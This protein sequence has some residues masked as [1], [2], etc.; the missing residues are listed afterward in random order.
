[1]SLANLTDREN[2]LL[3]LLSYQDIP[4]DQFVPG[5]SMSDVLGSTN[6]SDGLKQEILRSDNLSSLKIIDYAN[7]N[8]NSGKTSQGG[9]TYDS[10]FVGYCF[11]DSSGAH[12]FLF[13]GTEDMG[14][15]L[16]SVD[17]V[18]D[19]QSS[20]TSDSPQ[21]RDAREFF[22]KN[23]VDGGNNYLSGHS[24]GV[25][26][27]TEVYVDNPDDVA[28]VYGLNGQPICLAGLTAA[29]IVALKDPKYRFIVLPLDPVHHIK[30]GNPPYDTQYAMVDL[31]YVYKHGPLSIHDVGA[32]AY[33]EYGNHLK[34]P[35]SG[36]PVV[37]D[38]VLDVYRL[39]VAGTITVATARIF[40]DMAWA[41][42]VT[43]MQKG[44][45]EAKKLAENFV[46]FLKS[47]LVGATTFIATVEGFFSNLGDA[48][49]RGINSLFEG[50]G[51]GWGSGP[52]D[53][54]TDRLRSAAS[55]L[56]AAQNRMAS[57][58]HRLARLT[59]LIEPEKRWAVAAIDWSLCFDGRLGR[60]VSYLNWTAERLE[61]CERSIV[62]R[63]Y[64][65]RT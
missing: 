42:A 59:L 47:A 58:D 57:L 19:I 61:G 24:K 20:V 43:E 5:R 65:F 6:L 4:P 64:E 30:F 55:R 45:V 11:G 18:D 53:V 48:I 60:C 27:E 3:L 12:K 40:V 39:V 25:N 10:G 9:S 36:V 62:N 35:L 44:I 21:V 32:F 52:L 63:A 17:L 41:F 26:L 51:S 37:G 23:K 38:V 54:N 1:M 46:N 2:D 49:A 7:F 8:Q 28:D 56:Q 14:K 13:R 34:L 31:A 16:E 29:Q 50:G 33:D 15:G 22:D